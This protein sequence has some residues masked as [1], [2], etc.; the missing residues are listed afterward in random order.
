MAAEAEHG[1]AIRVPVSRT[2][3]HP[4]DQP[5]LGVD[6]LDTTV[7]QALLHR[8]EDRL[9]VF[10]DLLLQGHERLDATLPDPPDP[11]LS[12]IPIR[13]QPGEPIMQPLRVGPHPLGDRPDRAPRD[14]HQ[15]RHRALR[16]LRGQL[17]Q[18]LIERVRVP[19]VPRTRH[20]RPPPHADGTILAARAPPAPPAPSPDRAQI[21]GTSPPPALT[22]VIART[23]PANTHRTGPWPGTQDAPARSTVRRPHRA[24]PRPLR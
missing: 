24:R 4:S 23:R 9:A 18:L 3:G 11:S 15:R 7:G 22:V 1:Q 20:P 12:S 14:P 13:P 6:R 21:H 16:R 17:G 19:P 5:D 2:E 10:D 8:G